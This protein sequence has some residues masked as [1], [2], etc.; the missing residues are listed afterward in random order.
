MEYQTMNDGNEITI[1][2]RRYTTNIQHTKSLLLSIIHIHTN[3]I[4]QNIPWTLSI[5]FDVY[6]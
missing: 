5:C 4:I 6:K 3:F 2:R 1:T